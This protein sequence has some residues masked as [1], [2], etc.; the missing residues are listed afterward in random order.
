MLKIK[1]GVIM[2]YLYWLLGLVVSLVLLVYV[3]VFTS[4]GNSFVKPYIEEQIQANTKMDSKLNTFSLSM[5]DFEILLEINK[6][7]R[8]LLKG[9]YSLFSQTFNV[10]YRV[11]LENLQSLEPLAQTKLNGSFHTDG[12]VVGDMKLINVDGKSDI[13]SSATTYHVELTEFNPTSIIA[14]IDSANL[15]EL[16]YTVNQK[17][18][19]NAD[20]NLDVNFK[21]ITPHK[22]D[23][24]IKLTTLKGALN[25]KVMKNDFNIT[26]PKTAFSMTLDADLKGDDVDYTYALNSNLAK[27]S[28]GGKVVPEPLQVDIHYGV[29]IKE[30]AVLKPI[31]NAPLRGAFKVNGTVKGS[32][33]SMLLDGK[34]NFAASKTTY[35]VTLEEFAP[36]SVIASIKKARL[37]KLLYM[38]GQPHLASSELNMDVKFTSLDPKNLAGKLKLNLKN[39]R[40]DTKVMKKS[41]DVKI[42][43]TTFSSNTNVDL[44]GTSVLYETL[45][46]SN[47]AKLTSKGTIKPENLDMNL[48]YKA[49]IKE[50]ALLKPITGADLRGKVNLDGSLKG[51]NKKLLLKLHSDFASSNTSVNVVLNDLKPKSVKA[52]IKGLQLRKVLYM[53]KQPH[54]ADG[55]FDMEADISDAD[56]KSLKGTIVSTIKKGVLDSK[57]MTKEYKFKTRMPMTTFNFKANTTLNGDKVTQKVDFNSNLADFDIKKAIFT[58]SDSSLKSDYVVKVHNLDR[59]YFATD[60]HL[61]G[62][63]LAKGELKKAKDLDLTMLSNVAGGKLDVKLHNDDLVANLSKMRTLDVLDMLIYPKIFKS[64]IDANVK[65]NLKSSQGVANGKLSDGTFTKNQILDLTK[66]YAKI[67]MYTQKFKGDFHAN[68]KRENILA[69]LDLK[70][71]TSSIVT[72]GTRL[73]T[74]TQKINSKV[75]VSANGNLVDFY[76]S[77]KVDSPTVKVNADKLIKKEASKALKKGVNSLLKRFF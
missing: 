54:Y 43:K 66:K 32:K 14:K 23:G 41:F 60:R 27:I 16:L 11:R 38:V 40:V 67:N 30:L 72:K 51:D 61:K 25:T 13:A 4:L 75:S 18:Y 15:K 1:N 35:K 9:N 47:L 56:M 46:D 55:I 24:N 71:N 17:A 19:A 44:K 28:S 49:S 73:N 21:N 6:D 64:Y 69:S 26:I 70:S 58:I 68:I 63:L 45:F 50:L 62:N 3:A 8:V 7:N 29:D 12:K 34:S 10:A 2:K 33:K 39:G 53:V 37:E 48:V 5:S 76:L 65:Y 59:L 42:P 77:G 20:I 57:F 36:K 22:L 31:T 74:K 52:K